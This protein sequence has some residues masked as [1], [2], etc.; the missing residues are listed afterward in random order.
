MN[1]TIYVLID[2]DSY[3]IRASYD[4]DT[5]VEFAEKVVEADEDIYDED[6]TEYYMIKEVKLI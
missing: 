4:K 5:L 6:W 1:S 2:D 3:V